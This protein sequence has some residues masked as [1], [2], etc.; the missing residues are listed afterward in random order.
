MSNLPQI[1]NSTPYSG[2]KPQW[3]IYGEMDGAYLL[4]IE[5]YELC[6][7]YR[8][9]LHDCNSF[10]GFSKKLTIAKK[11]STIEYEFDR[12]DY[13]INDLNIKYKYYHIINKYYANY[14]K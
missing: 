2:N 6:K 5:I 13:D 1:V 4:L 14:P 11:N 12:E 10:K 7:V 9:P 3:L 8:I